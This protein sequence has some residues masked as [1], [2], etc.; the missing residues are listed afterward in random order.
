MVNDS[1]YYSLNHKDGSTLPKLA[2][3]KERDVTTKCKSHPRDPRWIST[4][5]IQTIS[6][7]PIRLQQRSG[8][9][10]QWGDCTYK[11]A[12]MVQ[13]RKKELKKLTEQ[14]NHGKVLARE[15]HFIN[16]H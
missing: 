6:Y 2:S 3:A 13:S 1:I 11:A 7:R 8:T 4:Q 5:P 9:D 16:D 10:I 12:E 14:F 15:K